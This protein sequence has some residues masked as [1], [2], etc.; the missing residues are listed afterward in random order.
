MSGLSG[1][2]LSR[3]PIG[4]KGGTLS[5]Y[6]YLND[7]PLMGMD[8][9]GLVEYQPGEQPGTFNVTG[10]NFD[11]TEYPGCCSQSVDASYVPTSAEQGQYKKI[12]IRRQVRTE[13]DRHNCV[14]PA[15][16][17]GWHSDGES[18]SVETWIPGNV[19]AQAPPDVPG[20]DL[21]SK[22]ER[23]SF[24]C[25]GYCATQSIFQSFEICA[26]GVQTDGQEVNLGCRRFE[27]SCSYQYEKS[28]RPLV[29]CL[30]SM[31]TCKITCSKARSGFARGLPRQVPQHHTR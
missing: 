16:D 9:S 6:L 17:T 7:Q 21:E 25:P 11:P 19:N 3:D 18:D 14:L 26:I 23:D 22:G 13:I 1:R 12:L 5:T 24:F 27:V 2:F 20:G 29:A 10:G 28:S 31:P 8:P 30:V 15:T 4:F